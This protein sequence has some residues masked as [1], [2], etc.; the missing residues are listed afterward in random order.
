LKF[1]VPDQSPEQA[2]DIYSDFRALH[3]A[4]DKRIRSIAFLDRER[5]TEMQLCVGMGDPWYSDKI[6]LILLCYPRTY[7]VFTQA[8]GIDTGSPI[9]V[10][11]ADA[12]VEEFDPFDEPRKLSRGA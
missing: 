7:L 6:L 9:M 4:A 10:Q 1:F 5:Q 12:R 11:I 8:R 2:E 3:N